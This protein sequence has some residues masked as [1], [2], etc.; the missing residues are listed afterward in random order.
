[1]NLLR[2]RRIAEGELVID[3]TGCV[4]ISSVVGPVPMLMP[5]TVIVIDEMLRLAAVPSLLMSSEPLPFVTFTNSV[6]PR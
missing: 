5:G 1:V 4:L 3:R 2:H 6:P